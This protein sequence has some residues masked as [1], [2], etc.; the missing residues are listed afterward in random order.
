MTDAGVYVV[1]LNW[2]GWRDTIAC[3][4]S[5]FASRHPRLRVVVCDNASSDDSLEHIAAWAEG[6]QAA[7]RPDHPRLA[8]LLR[9]EQVPV[10]FQ[11]IDRCTA[12]S[13]TCKAAAPL[14][15]IDNGANLG[16][17]AGNNVGLRFALGQED[18]EYAWLLNNDTL[19]EPDCLRNMLR[20]L[21]SSPPRAVC[22]SMIHF[23]D[24]PEIIQAVGGNRFNRLTGCA[25]RSEGR[26]SHERAALDINRIES[27]LAYLSGCS[28]LLPRDFLE[29]VGLMSE[30]YFLYY[31]EIDWFTRAAGRYTLRIAGDARLYHREGSSIGSR[32]LHRTASPLSDFHMFRSRLIF[33]RK[34]C[35]RF[36]ALC[37]VD[38]WVEVAKRLMR[39]QYRNAWTVGTVLLN[40]HPLGS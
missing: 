40:R 36:L 16:F 14:V 6:R 39:G 13:G 29:H 28:I 11:R 20:C 21:A 3:L 23:F 15:L 9:T 38:S 19:V 4:E 22:G 10:A 5:L 33:M 12:E 1:L 37:Y 30:D 17:A 31:E 8:R 26:F 2:N 35:Q 25:A 18:M 32:T 34:Y 7:E 27:E 24:Q